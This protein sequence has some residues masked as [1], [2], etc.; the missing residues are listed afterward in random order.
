MTFALG[1]LVAVPPRAEAR[2]LTSQQEAFVAAQFTAQ[3]GAFEAIQVRRA[4]STAR[5]P[6]VAV[7]TKPRLIEGERSVYA[8]LDDEHDGEPCVLWAGIAVDHA[9]VPVGEWPA[10]ACAEK[11]RDD[12]L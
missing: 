1:V 4:K 10:G 2:R 9:L 12:G 11:E 6:V 3:F 7:T 5:F 8:L